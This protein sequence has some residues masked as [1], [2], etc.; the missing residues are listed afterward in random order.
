MPKEPS[1]NID[2]KSLSD[3][4]LV[5]IAMELG[6][7][8]HKELVEALRRELVERLEAKGITKQEMVKRIALGVPRGRRFKKF[9][10]S[11][12]RFD[13]GSY[14]LGPLFCPRG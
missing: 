10:Q 9:G 11:P 12:R 5:E 4:R 7:S 2:V 14:I 13:N 1:W 6:G 8:E 3:R